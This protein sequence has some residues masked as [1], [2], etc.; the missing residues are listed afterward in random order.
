MWPPVF[1][2]NTILPH[3]LEYWGDRMSYRINYGS[4][5]RK[6]GNSVT[7]FRLSALTALCF[8]A[9]LFLVNTFWPEGSDYLGE[10]LAGQNTSASV[11]AL[12]RF[13]EELHHGEPLVEAFS[14]FLDTVQP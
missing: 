4:S 11:V 8:L 13:A 6:N 10:I 1:V 2:L 12:E 3:K 9:F 14:K 7:K 5:N